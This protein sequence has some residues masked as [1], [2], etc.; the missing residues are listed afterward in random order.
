MVDVTIPDVDNVLKDKLIEFLEFRRQIKKPMKQA[1]A[2]AFQKKLEKLSGGNI[3]IA[4]D[5]LEESIANGWQGIFP[6]KNSTSSLSKKWTA[7]A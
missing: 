6:L 2:K 4:C 1:S 7:Q 5:I 3:N